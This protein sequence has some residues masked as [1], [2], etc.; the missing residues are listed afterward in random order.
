MYLVP[1]GQNPLALIAALEKR[2]IALEN[3][4]K[5]LQLEPKARIGRPPKVKNEPDQPQNSDSIGHR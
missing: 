5:G 4:V 1:Q 2:V 3:L